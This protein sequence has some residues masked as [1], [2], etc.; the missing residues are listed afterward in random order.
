MVKSLV[1]RAL[2]WA[3]EPLRAHGVL[4]VYTTQGRIDAAL[5]WLWTQGAFGTPH[6]PVCPDGLRGGRYYYCDSYACPAGGLEDYEAVLEAVRQWS[7]EVVEASKDLGADA[8]WARETVLGLA[9]YVRKCVA[10]LDRA[11]YLRAMGGRF[12][13][14]LNKATRDVAR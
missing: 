8:D 7:E 4:W 10:E 3:F 2:D 5:G 14:R 12:R 11:D 13:R 9:D 1:Q 6:G